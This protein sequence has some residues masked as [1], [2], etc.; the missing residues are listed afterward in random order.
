MSG[1]STVSNWSDRVPPTAMSISGT[2]TVPYEDMIELCNEAQKDMWINV[3][4]LATPAFVQD[5]AQ[6]IDTDLD[7][8]LNVYVEYSNETWNNASPV[9]GQV[10]TAA[11][12]N[13]LV[14]QN[15]NQ[16]EMVAQ[17]SAYEEVLIAKTFD[18]VFGSGSSRVRPIMAAQAAWSQIASWQ[19]QF[20]Q[21]NYGPP[22]QFIYASAVAPY[23][24]LPSG[25]N[26]AGLTINQIFTGLN[27]YLKSDVVPWI[28]SDAAV[29]RQYGV[30][31]VAYEG[32]QAMQPQA[33][34]LNFSVLQQAQND[35][36]MYQ[37]YVALIE[38][39]QAAGGGLF[40]AYQLT[41]Q[42]S[43]FGFWGMLPTVLSAG[44]Q[45]YDALLSMILPA[46]DANLDGR[47]DYADFQTVEANYGTT[48]DY[49]EQGDFNG[50]G[51]VS[52]QDL[53]ILRQNLDPDGFTLGQF[54]QQALF[55]QLSTVDAPTALEYDGYGVTYASSMSFSASSGTVKLNQNSRG[56]AIVLGG[57]SYSEGLGV[58]ANSSVSLALDG[59]YTRFES[60]IGVDGTANSGS[61]V[62]YDV[63]GD[64]QLLYQSPTLTYASGAIPIDVNVSGVTKLTLEVL[65][66]PGS[67]PGVDNAVW[68]DAR[69]V[70]TA[71]FGSTLP[72]TLTWQVSQNGTVLSTQTT[73]SFVFD[74]VIGTYTIALTVTDAEGDTATASTSVSVV[75]AVASAS[76][77]MLDHS[78]E[79]N[80]VGSY[81]A[82]GYDVIGDA[83]SLPGYA[84]VTPSG[85]TTYVA[86]ASTTAPQA[87]DNPSD[88]FGVAA[89]WYATTSFTV[90]VDLTDGQAHDLELYFLDW[91]NSGRSEQVQVS[92]AATGALLDTE[93]VSSFAKGVYL[94]W[95]VSGN[96]LITITRLSGPNAVLN[97]LFFDPTSVT[98]TAIVNRSTEGNW[99]GTYGAQGYDV[100][101]DAASL[102][103]YATVTPTGATTYVA[104]ASTTAPQALQNPGG[105]GR[106]A[107]CW[108]ATTSFTVDV[109]L[110]DGQAHDLELYFLDWSN[111]GRSE[112]VQVSNA[113]TGALLDTETVSSFAKGVYL[114]WTVSGNILITITRLSGPNA[115]LNGLFFDPTSVTTDA[116]VEHDRT[117]QE[118]GADAMQGYDIIGD[119]AS[120]PN[121]VTIAPS[122]ASAY[123]SVASTADP[124][125]L[126]DARKTGSPQTGRS[127]T[128]P[129][130]T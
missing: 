116:V 66:A 77:F 63:Y 73:D 60:T 70:S 69:L 8:N 25:V 68:A 54:A 87:L 101:G 61:S 4:T 71:N 49:W 122:G 46:G 124:R 28:Q 130:W 111:S 99:I 96:I 119:A 43:Q 85:A 98:T 56:Q 86:A 40:D 76:H 82:Q 93:T 18:Q 5:L 22:S 94:E 53:N 34:D 38:D 16:S 129:L 6:L 9:F 50:D 32:G 117:T 45:K 113:A 30:P 67:N 126:Q 106:I 104:A 24:A 100:I 95:T 88:T 97:G 12:V 23:V 59:Q 31:L 11:K 91:S 52:W 128:D 102:P 41:G 48:G 109:D 19:L 2:G 37:L 3:P 108:Y 72:Y 10:L 107:A 13:P 79:G 1:G 20:I 103:G 47:V 120:M 80:W 7:P 65:P 81:G 74:A 105:S 90:D 110:T 78:T 89:C 17:Q 118:I 58:L 84:T 115:V 36:R 64:G 39:W 44:S 15:G 26:V 62:I 14:T 75:P 51:T 123:P 21:Q 33:N 114:E 125:A 42:G 27:Q 92:N 127:L 55:G 112:Q 121:A 57:V 83:A 29:A 35:P